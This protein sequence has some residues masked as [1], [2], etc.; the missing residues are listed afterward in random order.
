MTDM[1]YASRAS[2]L[3]VT[4]DSIEGTRTLSNPKG[5]P[6]GLLWVN[7]F[8]LLRESVVFA[9][10]MTS[11][12]RRSAQ[13]RPLVTLER[14][15]ACV[16]T[17]RNLH[18]TVVRRTPLEGSDRG[19]NVHALETSIVEHLPAICEAGPRRSSL[20]RSSPCSSKS[21]SGRRRVGRATHGSDALGPGF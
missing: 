8:V 2:Y 10:R 14:S 19:E 16:N 21:T 9:M 11:P 15:H 12:F 3:S 20:A 17:G 18:A 6:L 7:E 1:M 5:A 13:G 4:M